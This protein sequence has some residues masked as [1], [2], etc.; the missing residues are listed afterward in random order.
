M[1]VCDP[2]TYQCGKCGKEF[3]TAAERDQHMIGCGNVP[4]TKRREE[5]EVEKAVEGRAGMK[6][7]RMDEERMA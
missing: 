6:R 2:W 7:A 3:K 4:T 5:E 1:G